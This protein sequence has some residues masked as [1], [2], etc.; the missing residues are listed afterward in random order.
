MHGFVAFGS[1]LSER[2]VLASGERPADVVL[3]HHAGGTPDRGGTQVDQLVSVPGDRSG[4]GEVQAG[5]QL[6]QR[7]LIAAVLADLEEPLHRDRIVINPE[8]ESSPSS[9]AGLCPQA[10]GS[11]VVLEAAAISEAARR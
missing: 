10:R 9:A 6:R 4:G 1:G 11:R 7:G 8:R 2:D 5:Q 3:G